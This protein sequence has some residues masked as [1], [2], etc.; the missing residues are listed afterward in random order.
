MRTGKWLA[1][2]RQ[3]VFSILLIMGLAGSVWIPNFT[4]AAGSSKGVSL[5]LNGERV[6]PEIQVIKKGQY[7]FINLPFLT[8]YFPVNC[9]WD[10]E[11][12]AIGFRF[13]DMS[14]RMD[15][16]RTKYYV[17]GSRRRLTVAPFEKNG[18]LWLP[19]QFLLRLGLV[20]AEQDQHRLSLDW[21]HNYLLGVA[22]TR[23]EDRTA[24]QL[25]GAKQLVIKSSTLTEP[26]RLVIDLPGTIAH[27]TLGKI[28]PDQLFVEKIRFTQITPD[29]LRLVFELK[30]DCG[31]KIIQ[32]PGNPRRAS[33][34][35]NYRVDDI[36][37]QNQD[38][39][40][41]VFI[42]TS[43]PAVFQMENHPGG[44]QAGVG[45]VPNRLVV[46]LKGAT[47]AG[48]VETARGDGKLVGFIHTSQLDPQTVRM[49]MDLLTSEPCFIVR[50]AKDPNR[51][52]VRPYQ[53]ITAF[54]WVDTN[55]GGRL[56][57]ES[58]HEMVATIQKLPGASQVQIELPCAKV[59]PAAKLPSIQNDQVKGIGLFTDAADNVRIVL[60]LNYY[61][62]FDI[63]AA[64]DRRDLIVG[65]KKSPVIQKTIVIDAGHG[66]VDLGACGRQGT[67]EKEINL[68]VS[69]RLKELLEGAGA[70]VI[71]TR[72]DD[73]Y[74]G[75]YER[76]FIANYWFADL[77][78]SVHSNNQY[79]TSVHGIEVYHFP[80]R[81]ESRL[82]A[83]KVIHELSANTNF[84]ELGVKLNDFVVIRETT[85]PSILVELGYLSNFEEESIIKTAEYREKAALGI[86]QGIIDYYQKDTAELMKLSRN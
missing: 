41:K 48:N 23:Y 29:K 56:I 19:L 2:R 9:D 33:L 84:Q 26:N 27:F 55:T 85:M 11:D 81:Y 37:V 51:L 67:R 86:F 15:E 77:F 63:S 73:E 42:K 6:S 53:Q 1:D 31:F 46:D 4:W 66:G 74:I 12:G 69:M 21:D 71:M 8:E 25:T 39:Q 61:A 22:N 49:T 38:G 83:E 80:G 79:D 76:P 59:L 70:A 40:S 78:I 17:N 62:G 44:Y 10:P 28:I 57:I 7:S 72:S 45:Y 52:E 35:F 20:I 82:L 34:V 65:L 24:Y 32:D 18:Q 16:G 36:E 3:R 43:H 54:N 68:E 13:G 14:F 58:T 47:W 30:T 64:G 50:S 5:Y 75:L 60:D